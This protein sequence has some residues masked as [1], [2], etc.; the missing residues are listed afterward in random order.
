[1]RVSLWPVCGPWPLSDWTGEADR[2]ACGLVTK[3]G[4]DGIRTHDPLLAMHSGTSVGVRARRSESRSEGVRGPWPCG[5]IRRRTRP[6][7][8]PVGSLTALL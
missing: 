1:M 8:S 4:D 5:P 3:G 7:G 2:A 6:I